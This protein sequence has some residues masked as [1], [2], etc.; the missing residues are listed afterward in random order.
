MGTLYVMSTP[1]LAEALAK[2]RAELGAPGP[3]VSQK[4]ASLMMGQEENQC[5]RW[6]KRGIVPDPESCVAL[7]HFLDV[8]QDQLGALIMET[9]MRLWKD[10]GQ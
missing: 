2:R 5:N 10:A 6:E 9:R 4:D 1:T 3:P 8:T 7:M